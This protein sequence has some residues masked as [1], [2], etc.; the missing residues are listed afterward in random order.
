VCGIIHLFF[1]CL[2]TFSESRNTFTK[3]PSIDET[4]L[5]VLRAPAVAEPTG[6]QHTFPAL[7]VKLTSTVY[8]FLSAV[9][10]PVVECPDELLNVYHG[11][12]SYYSDMIAEL[13]S[14]QECRTSMVFTHLVYHFS[15]LS[16]M[17]PFCHFAKTNA[18]VDFRA[19]CLESAQAILLL[20][21][22]YQDLVSNRQLP[23]FVPMFVYAAGL[24]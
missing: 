13:K 22:S 9:S 3:T 15:L 16:L 12:L 18:P 23:V 7:L 17:R 4:V 1:E 5:Q 8:C 20:S 11:C 24:V 2:D 10:Q 21:T 6:Q 14:V 19:V